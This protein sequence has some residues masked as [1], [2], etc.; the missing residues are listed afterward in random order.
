VDGNAGDLP[1]VGRSKRRLIL[2]GVL[3]EKA[4]LRRGRVLA[5]V[6]V[7]DRQDLDVAERSPQ[8]AKGRELVSPTVPRGP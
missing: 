2:V 6:V 1:P 7:D 5:G 8:T 3:V 4:T